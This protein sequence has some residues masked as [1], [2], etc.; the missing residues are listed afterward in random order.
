M[1]E[2]AEIVGH[3]FLEILPLDHDLLVSAGGEIKFKPDALREKVRRVR[4]LIRRPSWRI[5]IDERIGGAH[6][7]NGT[8]GKC[9]RIGEEEGSCI[10]SP[11]CP[12]RK[13]R[14]TIPG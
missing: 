5:G 3:A 14:R 4:M 1:T 12:L 6:H 7:G 13:M 8:F 11:F 9:K 10:Q 2:A